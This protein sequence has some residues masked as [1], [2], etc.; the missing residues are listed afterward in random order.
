MM[1]I[2]QARKILLVNRPDRPRSTEKR[3]LQ[4]A[5]DTI[6]KDQKEVISEAIR[7]MRIER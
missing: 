6:L 2:E 7:E 1:T 5:I 4:M 3:Q